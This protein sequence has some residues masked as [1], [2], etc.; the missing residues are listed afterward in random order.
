M[1]LSRK[2]RGTLWKIVPPNCIRREAKIWSR[3]LLYRHS[4]LLLVLH[5][6]LITRTLPGLVLQTQKIRLLFYL[7]LNRCWRLG[8]ISG[9]TICRRAWVCIITV[10]MAVVCWG[11]DGSF[12]VRVDRLMGLLAKSGYI[13]PISECV[14]SRVKDASYWIEGWGWGV[15]VGVKG[16][17]D[18]GLCTE[19]WKSKCR[20]W[21]LLTDFGLWLHWRVKVKV[22][23]MNVINRLWTVLHWG[24]KFEVQKVNVIN[25][26]W[27]VT[28][29]E[30]EGQSAEDEH[31]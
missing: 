14:H 9:G 3:L 31:S 22:Q 15:G 16:R 10:C 5:T 4:L 18:F 17:D 28:A 2:E 13:R 8:G 26:L 12:G 24:V 6:M 27:T 19:E 30:S 21:T 7:R 20:R 29:L 1:V 11:Y 23:K 25:W